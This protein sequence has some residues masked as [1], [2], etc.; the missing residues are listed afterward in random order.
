MLIDLHTHTRPLSWDSYLDPDELVERSRA[1]GL[2]G[3]CLSEH[4]FFWKPEE[5]LALAKRHSYLVLPAI[6]INTDDGHILAY[7]L[8]KYVYGMHRSH[9]LAHHIDEA[10]GVMIA[11]HPY[12]R[13]MPWYIESE[14][15]YQ[16]A[17]E[18]AAR[19][20]AYQYCAALEAINGRGSDKENE[21]SQRLCELMAMPGTA[22]SDAHAR[23]DIGRCATEF[24]RR[25]TT[26]EELIE[27]LKANRFRPVELVKAA[28]PY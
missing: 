18:R 23:I 9:E 8:E 19:N 25:I 20:R 13:Q 15:D 11:A 27:E 26:I 7:G 10:H 28:T 24:E 4:D 14:L 22:G 5:I 6:E 17:L 12:R 3:I 21:F 1:A 16:E 2:D